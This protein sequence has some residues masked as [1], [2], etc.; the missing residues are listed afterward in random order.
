MT[1]RNL[2]AL[3]KSRSVAVIGRGAKDDAPDAQLVHNLI[4]Q[5]FNGPIMPVNPDRKALRARYRVVLPR[6]VAP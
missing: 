6:D 2:D 3:F 4:R 1:I 5:G